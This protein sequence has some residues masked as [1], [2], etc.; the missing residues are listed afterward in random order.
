MRLRRR[1]RRPPSSTGARPADRRALL[2]ARDLRQLERLS[3]VSLQ[4]LL[5]GVSGQRPWG[6][7]PA[8]LEFA[9]YRPYVPGDDLRYVDWNIR[10]RLGELLVKVA[11]EERSA[12]IDILVDVSRSMDFGD[13]NKLWHARRLAVAI[14]AVGL[15][16]ADVVRSYGLADTALEPGS[17]LDAPSMVGVLSD[18]VASL[19]GSARTDLPAAVHAYRRVREHADLVVLI[20]DGLVPPA[21]LTAALT[22]LA[23]QAPSLAFVHV[24]DASELRAPGGGPLELRD[25]ETGQLLELTLSARAAASYAQLAERFRSG[26]ERSVRAVGARYVLAP[27]EVEPLDLLA[28]GARSAGLVAS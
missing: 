3:V 15:L 8:G 17:R 2:D 27:T 12:E 18:Q 13:P 16:H 26:V 1:P 19:S 11:P 4:A 23:G 28:A 14:G 21:A 20:S 9:D 5:T 6:V 25:L 10:A 24:L 22:E 7:G